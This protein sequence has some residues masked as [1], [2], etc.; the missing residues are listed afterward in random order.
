MCKNVELS[1]CRLKAPSGGNIISLPKRGKLSNLEILVP[2][3]SGRNQDTAA[4][5]SQAAAALRRKGGGCPTKTDGQDLGDNFGWIQHFYIHCQQDASISWL[6]RVD[7]RRRNREKQGNQESVEFLSGSNHGKNI[8]NCR[9][10]PG[11]NW[12]SIIIWGL[13]LTKTFHGSEKL[14]YSLARKTLSLFAKL[15]QQNIF[16]AANIFATYFFFI[17]LLLAGDMQLTLMSV[18]PCLL[19]IAI[20]NLPKFARMILIVWSAEHEISKSSPSHLY[21]VL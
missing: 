20:E 6:W 21:A 11:H 5:E 8:P 15:I 4:R 17:T 14:I 12:W 3:V 2:S 16:D 9:P 19:Q 7:G 13:N 10:R 1:V 18:V